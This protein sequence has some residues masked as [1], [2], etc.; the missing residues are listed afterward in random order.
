MFRGRWCILAAI[1]GLAVG[2]PISQHA[3]AQPGTAQDQAEPQ[4][5]AAPAASNTVEDSL[6]RIARAMEAAQADPASQREEQRSEA[7]LQ[8]Q[9]D[10]AKWAMWMFFAA[11]LTWFVTSIGTFLIWRQVRLTREAVKDTGEATVAMQEANQIAD[12]TAYRQLRPYLW[13]AKSWIEMQSNDEPMALLELKNYGQTPALSHRGWTH[14]W[15]AEYPL[16][17]P[18]PEAPDDL[19]VGVGIVAPSQTSESRQPHG[20]PLTEQDKRFIR[21]GTAALYVY[22]AG[23][24]IDIFG[25][26]HFYRFI[27]F[28]N[29][30]A[31]DRGRLRSYSSG[32]VID[33]D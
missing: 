21:A 18:L 22:G 27:Y 30:D 9:R 25:K 13:V 15:L 10:M 28:S 26:E 24:Y 6:T 2:Y 19:D 23:T 32:N 33:T 20:L 14:S 8:A 29:G 31:F 16:R 4:E 5:E 7:D 17:N 11:L 12:R 1:A 3:S